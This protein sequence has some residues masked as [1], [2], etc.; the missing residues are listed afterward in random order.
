MRIGSRG[1]RLAL[2]QAE[3]VRDRVA[4]RHP[5]LRVE[6]EVIST[7]GDKLLDAPLAKIG[8]KGL[9]TKELEAALLDGRIDVAVHSAKDMPTA[10][11]DGLAIVAF[12][13]REDVRDV[14]VANPALVEARPPDAP[15]FSLDDVPRGARVGSSSLRR[16]S[17]LLALRPDLDVVDIRGNV[18]TRLRKLVEEDMA[19]TIL[20]AA[21]LV[22]LGRPDTVAFAFGFDQMLP[23]VGQ[24]ALAIEA[25]TDH[26]WT[27]ELVAALDHRPTALAVSA[28]RALLGTLE[29]GCQVPIAALAVWKEGDDGAGTLTLDAYVGSL[30][31]R[32]SVRGERALPADDPSRLGVDLAAEL[33]ERGAG[34]ILDEI[35]TP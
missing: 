23:A 4:E 12:T 32:R 11:P 16:R 28:E 34:E 27:E 24:G 22:R 21:G 2:V 35:R 10:V 9:F 31:G 15:P 30:D 33:L 19:G 18:E 14:F 5:G 17:Q 20:A 26:P 3:W 25:R 6:I 1:S 29:G 8:D 7:K 13:E